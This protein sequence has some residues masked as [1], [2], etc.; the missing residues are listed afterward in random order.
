MLVSTVFNHR[1][2]ILSFYTFFYLKKALR[3]GCVL[4]IDL[5]QLL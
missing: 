5:Q 4:N 1:V 3:V 2:F